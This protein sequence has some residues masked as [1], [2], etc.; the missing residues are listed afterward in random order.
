MKKD[1]WNSSIVVYLVW[2]HGNGREKRWGR[3]RRRR[4]G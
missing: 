3:W 1:W 2:I 4:N